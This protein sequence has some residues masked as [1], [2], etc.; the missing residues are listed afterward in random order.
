[1]KDVKG[2]I[3]GK[4]MFKNSILNP[5]LCCKWRMNVSLVCK[6]VSILKRVLFY[7]NLNYL[8]HA[9]NIRTRLT[10]CTSSL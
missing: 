7:F 10:S 5:M 4:R 9:L 2:R 8:S 3:E 1:M 6:G